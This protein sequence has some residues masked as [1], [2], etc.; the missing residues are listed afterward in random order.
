MQKNFKEWR[1]ELEKAQAKE[2]KWKGTA[3]EPKGM[4][5]LRAKITT[6]QQYLNP[7]RPCVF[8]R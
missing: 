8:F 6:L 7:N 2:E 3:N 1:E 5:R 4:K